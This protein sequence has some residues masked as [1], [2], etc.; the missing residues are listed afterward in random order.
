[1]IFASRENGKLY[2]YEPLAAFVHP[3]G[4]KKVAESLRCFAFSDK[5]PRVS[6]FARARR[7]LLGARAYGSGLIAT[8]SGLGS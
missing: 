6:K 5:M 2:F 8:L 1:M 7:D 3:S 4:E